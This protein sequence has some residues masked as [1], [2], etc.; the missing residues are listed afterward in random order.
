MKTNTY[1]LLLCES[2][3]LLKAI[4]D[5]SHHRS[6][7]AARFCNGTAFFEYRIQKS[8]LIDIE[9]QLSPLNI[10]HHLITC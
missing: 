1:F 6:I 10:W 3:R 2:E 4:V 8:S 5:V 9:L 7:S